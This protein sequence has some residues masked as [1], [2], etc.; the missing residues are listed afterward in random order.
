[1]YI[2]RSRILVIALVVLVLVATIRT[3]ALQGEDEPSSIFIVYA[4]YVNLTAIADRLK[5]YNVLSEVLTALQDIP[6]PDY[7]LLWVLTGYRPPEKATMLDPQDELIERTINLWYNAALVDIPLAD[8]TRHNYSLNPLFKITLHLPPQ[9]LTVPINGSDYWELLNT[10]ITT[11]LSDVKLEVKLDKYGVTLVSLNITTIRE[12]GPKPI[13]INVSDEESYDYYISFYLLEVNGDYL[14]LLFPGALS[15]SGYMSQAVKPIEGL[16]IHWYVPLVKYRDILTNLTADAKTWWITRSMDY[17]SRIV[18]RAV[19]DINVPVYHIYLPHLAL[20]RT[21]ELDD[22]TMNNVVNRFEDLVVDVVYRF[23]LLEKKHSVVVVISYGEKENV[24]LAGAIEGFEEIGVELTMTML[25]GMILSYSAV[26][27]F[28]NARL[29]SVADRARNLERELSDVK[30]RLFYIEFE[31][32]D[33]REQ[34]RSCEGDLNLAQS[35][36][37][38]LNE[39]EGKAREIYNTALLYLSTGLIATIVISCSLGYLAY[40]VASKKK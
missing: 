35:R 10:A 13:K 12:L 34:L 27:P 21:L 6:E 2:E 15:T 29:L 17:S 39:L 5:N 9:V 16:N 23:I 25:A 31:L 7:L 18:M 36:L 30:T 8:P 33:T 24:L 40:K 14:K 4:P 22:E 11:T 28:P 26:S 19:S 3:E 1:M 32:N 37:A 20:A 38:N